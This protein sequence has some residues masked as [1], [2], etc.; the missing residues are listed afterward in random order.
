MEFLIAIAII[1][2]FVAVWFSRKPKALVE[3]EQAPY[4]VETPVVE[5]DQAAVVAAS[6]ASALETVKKTRKPRAPK[7]EKAPAKKPAAKKTTGRKPKA[8]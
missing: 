3:A 7:A 5:I 4:K 2:A 1:V 8:K 6:E